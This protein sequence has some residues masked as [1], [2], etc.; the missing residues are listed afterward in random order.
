MSIS[1]LHV[2]SINTDANAS[3]RGYQYQILKTLETWLSNYLSYD[4]EE[5]YCDY[6]DDIF[7]KNE[8]SKTAKFRQI[9]LY[10]SNF[11]FKSEEIEKCIAHFFML[12]V[13][14][15][16]TNLEKEFVFEANSTIA[17]KYGDNDAELLRKW[18]DNQAQ[19]T[20][21]IL[22][23]CSSKV[24][25][26]VSNYIQDQAKA[27]KD[28]VDKKIITEALEVFKNLNDSNWEEFVKR[29]KW[30][31]LNVTP[32]QE[33]QTVKERIEVLITKLPF[34]VAKDEIASV[35]G[36]LSNIVWEKASELD[37]DNRKLQLSEIEYHLI[38]IGSVE[39]KWY[40]NVFEKWKDINNIDHFHIGEFYEVIDATRHCRSNKYL[41]VH[42]AVW[43]KLLDVF[44]HQLQIR[45]E[46]KLTAIYEH[47]WLRIQFV[48]LYKKPEGNLKGSEDYVR[49]YFE[50]IADFRNATEI[51]EAQSILN[52]ALTSC[53]L[54][55]SELKLSE[56]KIWFKQIEKLINESLAV[57]QNP[58]E[59]CHLLENLATFNLFN[60]AR[61]K[62]N[63]KY[64]SLSEPIEQLISIIDK[65]EY[66]NVSQLCDRLNAYIKMLI[67]IDDESNFDLIE[68]L[69]SYLQKLDSIVLKREGNYK[70]AKIQIDRGI[71]FLKSKNPFLVLKALNCFHRAKDLWHQ[72]ET[73][74]GLVLALINISQLYSGIGLNIAAKYYAL[75]G[76]WV[77]IHNGNKKLFKRIADSL[78]MLFYADFK[79]GSWMN[80]ITA[81]QKYMIAR[82]EF[83]PNYIGENGEKMPLK[84]IA[85]FTLLLYSSPLLS[86]ELK[87]L[88]DSEFAQLGYIKDEFINPL[89]PG[90]TADFPTDLSLKELLE[91]KLTDR[92]L[93]DIGTRRVISF[94][95]LGSSWKI[96][97]NNDYQTNAIAEE[98][99]AI[100]QIMLG[101]IALSKYDFHLVKSNI[102]LELEIKDGINFPEQLP[103]NSKFKWKVFSNYFDSKDP[104]DINF[105]TATKAGTLMIILNVVSL[106]TDEEFNN[107]FESLF[108]END[109]ANKTLSMNAYQKMY[110]MVF[111]EDGFKSLQRQYFNPVDTPFLDFPTDNDV[112]K[113]K[114]D[115]S[116]K[117]NQEKAMNY[118]AN[119]FKYS[120][121]CLY[122]TLAKLH[123][124]KNFQDLIYK[125]RNEG[126]QDWF[127][128]LTMLNF[129]LNYKA[130]R[131]LRSL[132]IDIENERLEKF[133]ELFFKY[134]KM[135]EKDCYIE[136]PVDAFISPEFDF[137]L[138]NTCVTILNVCG[139]ENKASFPNFKAIKEFLDVRFNMSI[140]KN[141][142]GNP[143]ADI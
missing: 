107:N 83:K 13:K 79:Q 37:P 15:D 88:I 53:I 43:L 120:N 51:E 111:A 100:L 102:E 143:L 138:Q 72:Q 12:H 130:D 123:N 6:E 109:L 57:S 124:Q 67:T 89:I 10:S 62:N 31:F 25:E 30:R 115:L 5:I 126:W 64:N 96:T 27:L 9:K 44:I 20:P 71:V 41:F 108:K 110:R 129:I 23:E 86:P 38:S 55:L 118:I 74:E 76:V 68:L 32:D 139:F 8:L 4:D 26:I 29:I 113:W 56:V 1:K 133:K 2:F 122:L 65:A 81:F 16:Y 17:R 46:F 3:L 60:L 45:R 39:D 95:A 104:K 49:N 36:L 21:E 112:L 35:F 134:Q 78:G 47:I 22:K 141:D 85:D 117:Y 136:F 58:S 119:R 105:N 131:E 59:T 18:Y 99:C 82:H 80:A 116:L 61:K 127:I 77:S 94:K 132:K 66:Y 140:D 73:I 54:K 121:Q 142:N 97:F 75:A 128:I 24:K 63:K 14:T 70:A 52:I 103:S 19:L 98:F 40:L 84:V 28:K 91:A 33:F 135:D 92:P 114:A 48:G 34:P 7:Q 90:L 11:S 106:L 101:E 50:N 93:N 69:V 87:V 137:Q 42:S 125:L